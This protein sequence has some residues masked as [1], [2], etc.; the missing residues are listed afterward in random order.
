MIRKPSFTHYDKAGN[1]IG[2]GAALGVAIF[3]IT[4]EPVWISIG[5]VFG[6]AL[7]FKRKLD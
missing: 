2:V 3:T 1:W 6:A 5:V 7:G 4:N